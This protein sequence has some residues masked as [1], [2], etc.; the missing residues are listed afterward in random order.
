MCAAFEELEDK[1]DGP[2]E[3]VGDG[4][5]GRFKQTA[6]D[7]PG[8]GGGVMSVMKGRV[9]EKVGVNIRPFTANSQRS[10]ER[11][12]PARKKTPGSGHRAS[13]WCPTC[14]RRWCPPRI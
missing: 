9:F 11:T 3:A 7:R 14:V 6:W 2:N 13:H 1:V 4:K 5:P 8:G 12:S 10:S